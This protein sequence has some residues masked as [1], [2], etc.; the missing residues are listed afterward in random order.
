MHVVNF[1]LPLVEHQGRSEY[2]HRIGKSQ[3]NESLITSMA[4][5]DKVVPHALE[6]KVLPLPSTLRKTN[7]WPPS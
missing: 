7:P 5:L 4:H 2:V 1:D 6:M 3:S